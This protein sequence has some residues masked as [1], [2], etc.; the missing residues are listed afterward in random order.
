MKISHDVY[1]ETNPAF[2]TFVLF[3]FVSAYLSVNKSGPELPLAYLSLPLALSGDLAAEFSGTNKNT[4]LLEWINR[5]PVV[6]VAVAERMNASVGIVTEALRFAC[7]SQV[8]ALGEDARMVLGKKKLKKTPIA[9]LSRDPANA[10][11]HAERLGFWF[12]KAG[13]TRAVF[14]TIG[15]T[16]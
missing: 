5:S 10:I 6:Q 3:G 16:A 14:D 9:K 11:K 1:A 12:A 2:C 13:S 7:F 15:L 4:G 8:L